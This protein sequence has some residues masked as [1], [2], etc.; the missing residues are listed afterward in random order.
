[1][2]EHPGPGRL[3]RHGAHAYTE[4][5]GVGREGF[6]H[7][8]HGRGDCSGLHWAVC[9]G[10]VRIGHPPSPPGVS[11]RPTRSHTSVWNFRGV[12]RLSGRST[13]RRG[14]DLPQVCV[15]YSTSVR[16]TVIGAPAPPGGRII[17]RWRIVGR[18]GWVVAVGGIWVIIRV[19]V[20]RV[21][22]H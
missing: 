22:E 11:V 19:I 18:G 2:H 4:P 5:N 8:P 13:L 14:A 17:R 6:E 3:C 20:V 1:R 12:L 21:R 15:R 9:R 10:L 7:R 16:V